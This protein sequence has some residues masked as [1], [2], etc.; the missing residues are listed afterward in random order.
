MV[1]DIKNKLN[2]GMMAMNQN[3]IERN[4]GKLFAIGMVLLLALLFVMYKFLIAPDKVVDE[5]IQTYNV[6]IDQLMEKNREITGEQE[7]SEIVV[8]IDE[9]AP[10]SGKTSVS[11]TVTGIEIDTKSIFSLELAPTGQ[12]FARIPMTISN[13]TSHNVLSLLASNVNIVANGLTY[14]RPYMHGVYKGVTVSPRQEELYYY[15]FLIPSDTSIQSLKIGNKLI[16]I[17]D[18]GES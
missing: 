18:K 16:Q 14:D 1:I 3:F 5:K 17:N 9:Y 2:K 4:K 8:K 15:E 11:Y 12:V 13:N 10:T 6:T 7:I